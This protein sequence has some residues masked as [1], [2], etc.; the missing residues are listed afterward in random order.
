M[1]RTSPEVGSEG[2]EKLLRSLRLFARR[3][4]VGIDDVM[5]DVTFK[6]LRHETVERSSAS[7][8]RM[9]NVGAVYVLDECF[10]DRV[11]LTSDT[12]DAVEELVPVFFQVRH[13]VQIP[14]GV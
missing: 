10:L 9:K 8:E 7:D 11:Q 12:A 2:V 1:T 5:T 3:P 13:W 14:Y 6:H 4:P